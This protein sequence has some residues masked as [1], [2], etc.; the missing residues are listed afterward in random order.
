MSLFFQYLEGCFLLTPDKNP[1]LPDDAGAVMTPELMPLVKSPH[2]LAD[3]NYYQASADFYKGFLTDRKLQLVV[4]SRP[5]GP[6]TFTEYRF[7]FEPDTDESRQVYAITGGWLFFIRHGQ[8]YP[9][10]LGS[11]IPDEDM[12][13]LQVF[14]SSHKVWRQFYPGLL[15]VLTKAGYLNIHPLINP[16]LD[17]ND[18]A[19]LISQDTTPLIS[20][21]SKHL[22]EALFLLQYKKVTGTN[23]TGTEA[24]DIAY[25]RLFLNYP[26]VAI[27]LSP[28]AQIGW[29]RPDPL[30]PTT[31]QRLGLLFEINNA[32]TAHEAA[33]KNF[34]TYRARM[35]AQEGHSMLSLLTGMPVEAGYIDYLEPREHI[36][37]RTKAGLNTVEITPPAYHVLAIDPDSMPP[38]LVIQKAPTADIEAAIQAALYADQSDHGTTK[39]R[40]RN[41]LSLPIKLQFAPDVVEVT[42][43]GSPFM[44]DVAFSDAEK[45]IS[46]RATPASQASTPLSITTIDPNVVIWTLQLEFLE[47]T[48]VPVQFHLLYDDVHTIEQARG[49]IT[50]Q[51]VRE[52]FKSANYILTRQSNV[53]LVPVEDALGV[54]FNPLR[55]IGNLGETVVWTNAPN[56]AVYEVNESIESNPAFR[57]YNVVLA[58]AL[59][60]GSDGDAYGYVVY[61]NDY[62]YFSSAFLT[63]LFKGYT[64]VHEM[65]HWF[66]NQYHG[67]PIIV[68]CLNGSEHYNHACENGDTTY[69]FNL[70]APHVA[71]E[72][73]NFITIRQAKTFNQNISP[74][75][76]P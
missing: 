60:G 12:F 47:F 61:K 53:Y 25:F 69:Y 5:F 66:S 29:V 62:P 34:F 42:V 73:G 54:N 38:T 8:S 9:D 13:L 7:T 43:D 40:L 59:T 68:Q 21:I 41:P 35:P 11:A 26:G 64:L 2:T 39:F 44:P 58:W 18:P 45:I 63:Y 52:E 17:P 22:T 72:G 46:F 24:W 48:W 55:A 36:G 23:Y 14:P 37:G 3:E 70:M 33:V 32:W 50:E 16:E 57:S 6:S 28:D 56:T 65:L 31:Q 4:E 51:H 27:P 75:L 1:L 71:I 19:T 67:L 76:A 30:H 15:P 20:Q 10:L 49:K 74:L